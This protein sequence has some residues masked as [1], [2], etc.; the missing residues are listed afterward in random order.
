MRSFKERKLAL[1]RLYENIVAMK[2]EIFEALNQDLN[3]SEVESYMT[4]VGLSLSEIRFMLRKGKRYSRK[5][6]VVS[7]LSFQVLVTKYLVLMVV[8]L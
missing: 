4:E 7:P 2:D 3:K 5:K 8:Y 1:K 6:R